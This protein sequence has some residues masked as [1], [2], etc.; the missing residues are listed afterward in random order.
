MRFRVLP[1]YPNRIKHWTLL[2]RQAWLSA[3]FPSNLVPCSSGRPVTGYQLVNRIISN[4]LDKMKAARSAAFISCS[5]HSSERVTRRKTALYFIRSLVVSTN[6]FRPSSGLTSPRMTLPIISR[7]A[8]H[9]RTEE[10]FGYP[11]HGRASSIWDATVAKRGSF[12]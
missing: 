4:R 7:C 3:T 9:M 1:A 12:S 10:P 8:R 2:K 5:C 11:S 6:D